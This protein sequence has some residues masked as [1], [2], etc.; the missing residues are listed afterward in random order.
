M[1]EGLFDRGAMQSV[2]RL[3]QFTGERH[4]MLTDNIA[5]LSTPNFR[6]RDVDP[7]EFR[8]ALRQAQD[9]RR[10]SKTPNAGRLEMRNTRNM[11]FQRDGIDTRP[12]AMNRNILFHDRNNRDLERTMQDL[13]ENTLAH[14]VG[15]E[16]LKNE[17]DMLKIAI[18][19]RM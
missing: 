14:N 17:F 13:A 9:Q 7:G 10:D 3:V 18:R 2:E 1:I 15:I 8:S 6:P 11:T 12:R 19:E 16:L 5:N 4:R